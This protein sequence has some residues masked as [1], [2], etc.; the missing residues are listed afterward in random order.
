ME[1]LFAQ[2]INGLALGSIYG[3]LILGFTL[4]LLVAGIFHF[5][6]PHM[7]V[8]AIY[9]AWLT[10]NATGG[11]VALA[12]LASIGGSLGMA[13][14]I[15]PVFRPLTK[16]TA[17]IVSMV[18]SLGVSVIFTDIMSRVLHRGVPIGFPL[19]FTGETPIITVGLAVISRGQLLTIVGSIITVVVFL[20]LLYRTSMGRSFRAIAQNSFVARLVG[21]PIVKTSRFSYLIAGFVGGLTAVFI[22][23]FLG[24]AAGTLGDMLALKVICIALF[25]GM[26]NLAGGL[27]CALILG[28]VETFVIGYLPGDWSNAVAFAMVM[29]VIMWKPDG[30][31]GSR[32]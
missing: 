19:Y 7:V 18:V 5:A 8:F 6:Y 15:E 21:I 3:L 30:L 10:L 32:V 24:C 20:Y 17:L 4:L 23:M 16:R 31:F 13:I 12:I 29:I 14:A 2:T 26:G 22:A 27:I 11:N 9:I 25:A 1:I 28:L